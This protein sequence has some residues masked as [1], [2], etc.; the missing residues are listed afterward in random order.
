MARAER[1]PGRSAPESAG[2]AADAGRAADQIAVVDR[3][4]E[5]LKDSRGA[6]IPLLQQVQAEIGYLPPPVM[7]RIAERVGVSPARVFGVAT[8]YSQ[9]RMEPVGRH[10]IRVCHGT[11]CHVQGATAITEA[12]CSELGV[13]EGGTTADR[14]FTVEAVACLGCCSLAPV[15]MIDDSTYG[16][17]TPDKARKVVRDYGEALD[18][19]EAESR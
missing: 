4:A 5:H 7:R 17:L 11:A 1:P 8:F 12:I 9:F 19:A 14:Q 13:D 18:K 2:G 16:R 3:V 10:I 6:L 15:I